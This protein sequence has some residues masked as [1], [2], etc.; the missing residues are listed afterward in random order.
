MYTEIQ[1]EPGPALAHLGHPCPFWPPL[2]HRTPSHLVTCNQPP[3]LT[4]LKFSSGVF[5]DVFYL[6][7]QNWKISCVNLR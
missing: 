1:F 4:A 6:I 7:E 5:T 3:F 2:A